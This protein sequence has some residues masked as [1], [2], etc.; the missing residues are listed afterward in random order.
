MQKNVNIELF[1]IIA[2]LM[3]IAVHVLSEFMLRGAYSGEVIMSIYA[4]FKICVPC[5]LMIMGYLYNP[6]KNVKKLWIKNIYRLIIPLLLFSLFYQ[7]FAD[8]II[9]HKSLNEISIG[10]LFT[11]AFGKSVF[12]TQAFHLWYIYGILVIYALYPMFSFIC[13]D[14]E[15]CRSLERYLIIIGFITMI[16]FPTISGLFQVT[17][18]FLE[19]FNYGYLYV[20]VYFMI[21]N[22][23]KY[24]LPKIKVNKYI[25]LLGYFIMIGISIFSASNFEFKTG[26]SYLFLTSFSYQSIFIALASISFFIFIMK[27]K[28]KDNKFLI[29][30]GNKTL[31]V[32]FVHLIFMNLILLKTNLT[33]LTFNGVILHCALIVAMVYICSLLVAIVYRAII[34][35]LKK[36]VFRH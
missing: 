1:R 6:N 16:I 10:Y 18:G 14:D 11:N 24:L 19:I 4:F 20:C 26:R 7:V 2:I 28:I 5:F 31:I 12:E 32:Y 25:F 34:S 9:N 29:F 13:K 33:E 21:G 3:V 23:M 36:Y 17:S 15:K 8:V 30:L 27:L 22:Y 35:I